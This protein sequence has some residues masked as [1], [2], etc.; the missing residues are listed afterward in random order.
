MTR[1]T[2]DMTSVTSD[3]TRVTDDVTRITGDISGVTCGTVCPV[4]TWGQD[5]NNTCIDCSEHGSCDPQTGS[6]IFSF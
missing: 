4:N 3:M 2:G 1:I 6:A 5:C